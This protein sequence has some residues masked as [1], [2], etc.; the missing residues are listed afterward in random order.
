MYKSDTPSGWGLLGGQP[1]G[2]SAT[3]R[4][5]ATKLA[6]ENGEREAI[7]GPRHGMRRR[8]AYTAALHEACLSAL[9][10]RSCDA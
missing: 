5:D 7:R 9:L 10:W 3:D 4:R 6:I 2:G 8:G 1:A